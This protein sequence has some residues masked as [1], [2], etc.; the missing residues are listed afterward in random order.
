MPEGC[1]SNGTHLLKFKKGAFFPMKPIK[2]VCFKWISNRY[3][4]SNIAVNYIFSRITIALQFHRD[5]EIYE[6][7]AFDPAKIG[8][9]DSKDWQKFAD[10][11]KEIMCKVLKCKSSNMTFTDSKDYEALSGFKWDW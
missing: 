10:K 5:L 9:T 1:F 4:M 3:N 7:D 2:I 6:F 11:T 8:L